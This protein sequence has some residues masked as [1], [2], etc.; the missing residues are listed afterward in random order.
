VRF[1]EVAAP[2]PDLSRAVRGKLRI[3]EGHLVWG[4]FGF[5]RAWVD[6]RRLVDFGDWPSHEQALANE[7]GEAQGRHFDAVDAGGDAQ[8]QVGDHGGDDLQSDGVFVAAD[9]LAD[10]ETHPSRITVT[11]G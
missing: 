2:L 10:I 1:A 7:F 9:E 11:S 4:E 5:S 6:G 8:Q 3:A